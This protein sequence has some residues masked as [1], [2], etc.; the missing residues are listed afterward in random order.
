MGRGHPSKDSVLSAEYKC[1]PEVVKQFVSVYRRRVGWLSLFDQDICV[2]VGNLV[3]FPQNPSQREG[4]F[5]RSGSVD[6]LG[7]LHRAGAL[8]ALPGFAPTPREKSGVLRSLSYEGDS[9][10]SSFKI[11]SSSS[12]P[13]DS[14]SAGLG[15]GPGVGTV[16]GYLS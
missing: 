14:D 9:L 16:N 7:H 13:R 2:L 5:T 11:E 6:I 1:A 15:W 4:L 3:W 8:G 10:G 12:T